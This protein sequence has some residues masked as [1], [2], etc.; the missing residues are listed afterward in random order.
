[1]KLATLDNQNLFTLTVERYEI[2]D[3]EVVPTEDNPAEDFDTGRFLTVVHEFRNSEG[4]WS[5]RGPT[6]TTD[7]LARFAEWL[8]S[9]HKGEPVSDGC[10]FTERD[11][12]FT[13]DSTA[14]R[15]VA[16]VFRD[17]L[18]DWIGAERTVTIEFPL[19]ESHLDAAA[20]SIRQQL[21]EFPGRPPVQ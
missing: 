9:I 13:F 4:Q 19:A 21:A 14:K 20:A 11:L 2:P 18:P 16:H 10:Y 7:E 5:A 17:F 8:E 1:M 15:L 3:E 6:M 12:E